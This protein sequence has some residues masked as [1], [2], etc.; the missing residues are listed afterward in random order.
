MSETN[1]TIEETLRTHAPAGAKR[2]GRVL[3]REAA[4]EAAEEV[5]EA[6]DTFVAGGLSVETAA[7]A[8]EV[9]RGDLAVSEGATAEEGELTQ[10]E[11]R[12]VGQS[13]FRVAWPAIAE[14]ALQTLLGIVDT[15]VVARLGTSALSGV[16]A[17][18]QL[19]WVLTTALIAVSM[20]TTVL[21]ARFVGA[22]RRL[23]S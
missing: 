15:A 14:N 4:R 7:Q 6:T 23:E 9:A 2:D 11:R 8:Q 10:E 20:G 17:A 21:V 12:E 16:G 18:Q 19:V 3:E 22:A 13:V 5:A 1:L